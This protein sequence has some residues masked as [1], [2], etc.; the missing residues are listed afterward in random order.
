[1]GSDYLTK[2]IAAH[3]HNVHGLVFL[4]GALWLSLGL[5]SLSPPAAVIVAGAI[6]LAIGAWPYLVRTALVRRRPR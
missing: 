4:A 2:V 5:R 1:L 6:L 3:V